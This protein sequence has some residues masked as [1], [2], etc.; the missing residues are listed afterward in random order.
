MVRISR[1]SF[2][3]THF[4]GFSRIRIVQTRSLHHLA[5]AFDQFDLAGDFVING[6][7]QELEGIKILDFA[8]RA[9]FG[10][11]QRAHGNVGVTAEIAF[12]HIA[13]RNTKPN[14]QRV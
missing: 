8:A 10:T 7:L 4:A 2:L 13:A 5:S 11:T 6:F 14:N 1:V 3:G 12:L 9:E